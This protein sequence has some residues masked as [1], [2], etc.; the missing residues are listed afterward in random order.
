MKAMIF[1]AGKGER[2]LPLTQDTPKPL[3]KI[4]NKTLIEYH[5]EKL[6]KAGIKEV[7]I[8]VAWMAEKIMQA[9]GDGKRFGLNI[10]YSREP[11]PLET[12]GAIRH[13]Q[14]L[15]GSKPVLVVNADVFTDFDFSILLNRELQAQESARL[16]MVPNPQHNVKGDYVLGNDGLIKQKDKSGANLTFAGISLINPAMVYDFPGKEINFPLRDVFALAISRNNLSGLLYSG[17]W[18]DVGTPERLQALNNKLM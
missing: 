17:M 2:M 11:N 13:A 6:A 16:V 4:N 7:V 12:A 1:A 10:C 5:L 3:L 9:L 14:A 18:S 15:L 8:N